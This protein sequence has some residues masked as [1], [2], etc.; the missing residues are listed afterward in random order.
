MVI[1]IIFALL[2][3]KK[4]GR[5]PDDDQVPGFIRL[6]AVKSTTAFDLDIK[7]LDEEIQSYFYSSL[8]SFAYNIF[9]TEIAGLAFSTLPSLENIILSKN[10]TYIGSAAFQYNIRR[11]CFPNSTSPLTLSRYAFVSMRMSSELF[12]IPENISII[13]FGC[14][15][16]NSSLQ[17]IRFP[18]VKKYK[19]LFSQYKCIRYIHYNTFT[20]NRSILVLSS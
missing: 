15:S 6:Y 12:V 14:F 19:L 17:N 9:V 8:N 5:I 1:H 3:T 20:R 7:D 10:I 11:H 16:E 13:P 18:Y 4:Y 2:N